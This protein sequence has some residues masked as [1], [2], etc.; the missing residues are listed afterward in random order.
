MQGIVRQFLKLAPVLLIVAVLVTP[1][2]ASMSAQ[3]SGGGTII[4]GNF[5]GDPKN[6]NPII[7]GDT[8]SQRIYGFLFPTLVSVDPKTTDFVP[9]APG[10]LAASWKV[11]DDQKTYTFTLRKDWKWSDGKPITAHDVEYTYG[12]INDKSVGSPLSFIATANGGTIDSMKALDDYTLEVKFSS[13]DCKA[14]NNAGIQVIPSHLFKPDYSDL[15]G[16]DFNTNP[17]VSAGPFKFKEFVPSQRVSLVADQNYPD[18]L[19]K[20]VKP[21]GFIYKTVADQNVL[22]EQFL[23]GETNVIDGP[24]VSRRAEIRKNANVTVYDYPGNAWDY[25]AY[26][27]ADPTNPQPA[28]DKDGKPVDQGHHPLFG[29]VAVRQAIAHAVD[30]KTIIQTAANGEGV[31]MPSAFIPAS[32]AFDKTLEPISLDPKVAGDMLDKAGFPMGPNGIRVAKGAKYAKD[33]TPFK[34]TLITNSGNSRREKIIQLIQSQL[35]AI[36][37]DVTVQSVDFNTVLDTLNNEKFDAVVLGWRQGFPD[38]PDYTQLFDPH[39]DVIGDGNNNPMSYNN[40]QLNDL[41]K[42]ALTLPGCKRDDRAA[43]YHQIGKILQDDQP[44]LFLFAVNGE[45]AA[46]KTVDGFAPLPS[47]LYWNVD[48]WTVK[49]K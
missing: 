32:W 49:S 5:G 16:S 42:K 26:N 44:Y 23:A 37:I 46:Q 21:D 24:A 28:F 4:E 22:L 38:D 18:A 47:Q 14:L 29:D 40:Q 36:G 8:A 41:E 35:K 13:P 34:F 39:S 9:N 7:G 10:G 33:G 3:S 6:L 19:D 31:Q 20:T 30:V 1:G 43:I 15:A 11:S 17:N 27:L 45:Y 2:I 48:T 12:A 25:M